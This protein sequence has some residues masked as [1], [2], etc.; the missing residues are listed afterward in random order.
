MPKKKGGVS[1]GWL[2]DTIIMVIET[3]AESASNAADS[4]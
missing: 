4:E 1:M 2:E 3:V